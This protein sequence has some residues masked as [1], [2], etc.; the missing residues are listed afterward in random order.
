MKIS[1]TFFIFHS[2]GFMLVLVTESDPSYIKAMQEFRGLC[3]VYVMFVLNALY[4]NSS[5]S[6]LSLR[7][8]KKWKYVLALFFIFDMTTYFI[9]FESFGRF[10]L[11][12]IFCM[13]C[14]FCMILRLFYAASLLHVIFAV[15]L[16]L[17]SLM[18][19]LHV[20]WVFGFFVCS[21]YG[22]SRLHGNET[23]RMEAHRCIMYV[24]SVLYV[25]HVL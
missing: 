15:A 9:R 6:D 8:Y 7:M 2:S 10:F 21:G 4:F 5:W 23:Q 18:Y 12:R 17:L 22:S 19:V 13:Y 20:L 3:V 1:R 14:T 16:Y 24:L 25:L 11:L